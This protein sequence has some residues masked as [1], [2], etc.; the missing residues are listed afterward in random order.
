MSTRSRRRKNIK[1]KGQQSL[2]KLQAIPKKRFWQWLELLSPTGKLA[3]GAALILAI[4]GTYYSFS[5]KLYVTSTYSLDPSTPFSTKFDIRNESLLK[6]YEIKP[7]C[8][9]VSV[10]MEG[11]GGV[12]GPGTIS[13]SQPPIPYLESGESTSFILPLA[14]IKFVLRLNTLMSQ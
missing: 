5:P 14:H 1:N 7:V 4:V 9:N 8:K 10:K 2:I 13:T 11:G 3:A 6:V 12:S